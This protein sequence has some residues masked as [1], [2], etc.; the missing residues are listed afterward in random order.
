MVGSTEFLNETLKWCVW[1]ED[2]NLG[3]VQNIPILLERIDKVRQH[4]IN[5]NSVERTFTNVPWKFVT[6]KRPKLDQIVIPAVTTSA[7]EYIPIGF[8]DRSIIV[9]SRAYCL[10]DAKLFYFSLLS[11]SMHNVWVKTVSGRLGDAINYSSNICYNTFPVPPLSDAQKEKLGQSARK[12]LLTRENHSEKTLA[13]MYDPDKMPS[14]LRDAH[15]ENDHIVD[16]L[17]RQKG[18]V[19]DEERLAT[20][21]DLYVQMTNK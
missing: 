8:L 15:G 16:K 21:F 2:E 5:G 1:I 14:D 7:R 20:L 9:N 4:R 19:N 10:F 18:F 11:S 17:Y 6:T 12:I 13:Q 3:E